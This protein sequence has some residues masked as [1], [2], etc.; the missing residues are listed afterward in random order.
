MAHGRFLRGATTT[1]QHDHLKLEQ[2]REHCR[3]HRHTLRRQRWLPQS[4][5]PTALHVSNH[6]SSVLPHLGATALHVSNHPAGSPPHVP[7]CLHLQPP[8][9]HVLAAGATALRRHQPCRLLP[10]CLPAAPAHACTCLWPPCSSPAPVRRS[11]STR[12]PSSARRSAGAPWRWGLGR[13]GA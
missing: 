10:T 4:S 3:L 13:A 9:R 8:R 5:G 12:G 2:C 1:L 11:P 7:A 6:P